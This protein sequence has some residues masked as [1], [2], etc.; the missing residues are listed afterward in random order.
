R[1]VSVVSSPRIFLLE[2]WDLTPGLSADIA[3]VD[4]K[5]PDVS[6]SEGQSEPEEEESIRE[7]FVCASHD[8]L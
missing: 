8:L 1:K 5:S 3:N 2:P 6:H 4:V 7:P